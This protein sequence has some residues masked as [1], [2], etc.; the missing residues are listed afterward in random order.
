[1]EI[2]DVFVYPTCAGGCINPY[3]KSKEM[4]KFHHKDGSVSWQWKQ[5]GWAAMIAI[6]RGRAFEFLSWYRP[7]TLTRATAEKPSLETL[8][9]GATLEAQQ[10]GNLH[11]HSD[12]AYGIR[13]DRRAA[14]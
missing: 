5:D 8:R 13:K 9:P 3:F 11:E 12:Q 7:L 10:A 1:M 14:N 4:H 6:D 2:G